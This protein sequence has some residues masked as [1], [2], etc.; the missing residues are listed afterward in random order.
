MA[1]GIPAEDATY[2]AR[3]KDY[4]R[5]I[6]KVKTNP[7]AKK[8]KIEALKTLLKDD[9]VAKNERR[10]KKNKF[11]IKKYENALKSLEE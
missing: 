1:E 4:L 5:Y 9:L 10:E 11:R 3:E 7:I 8:V 6:E 2:E